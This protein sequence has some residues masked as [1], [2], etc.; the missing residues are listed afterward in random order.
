MCERGKVF[1]QKVHTVGRNGHTSA[2]L[3][4]VENGTMSRHPSPRA[5]HLHGTGRS[6][7]P[8]QCA[9]KVRCP[10]HVALAKKIGAD[11]AAKQVPYEV[12][13]KFT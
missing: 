9:A 10:D 5:F 8:T 6:G 7:Q 11:S 2:E 1:S 12:R 3:S 13:C 4:S